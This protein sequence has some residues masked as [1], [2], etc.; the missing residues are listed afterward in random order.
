M[1]G[2]CFVYKSADDA[3]DDVEQYYSVLLQLKPESIG[4]GLPEASFFYSA[5]KRGA[6]APFLS[7]YFSNEGTFRGEDIIQ[8]GY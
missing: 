7:H 3:K 5:N 1:S 8:Q 2:F 6:S 4:S